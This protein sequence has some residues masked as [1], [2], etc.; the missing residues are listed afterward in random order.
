MPATAA[1]SLP[2]PLPNRCFLIYPRERLPSVN[3][4]APNAF[5]LNIDKKIMF[6]SFI[7]KSP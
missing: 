5:K 1:Q 3:A 4:A 6:N 7:D 2:A